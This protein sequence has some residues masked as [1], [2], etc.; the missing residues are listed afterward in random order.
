[1]RLLE[2]WRG[3]EACVEIDHPHVVR[4]HNYRGHIDAELLGTVL[5]LALCGEDFR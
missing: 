3:G 4:L 5:M 2:E 1:M